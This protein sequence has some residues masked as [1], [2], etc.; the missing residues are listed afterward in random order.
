[1]EVD[2]AQIDALNKLYAE[3]VKNRK[4]ISEEEAKLFLDQVA[5][6][7]KAMADTEGNIVKQLQV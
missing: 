5:E 2:Q 6:F 4:K 3:A 7:E 1:M